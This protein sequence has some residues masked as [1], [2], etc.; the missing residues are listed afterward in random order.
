MLD[1]VAPRAFVETPLPLIAVPTTS[2]TGSEVT[3]SS[4]VNDTTRQIKVSLRDWAI[5]PKIAIVDPGLTLGL[6]ALLTASTGMDAFT[7]A[8]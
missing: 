7:H 1:W 3:R 8:I 6:P 5:A 2:G 4:V